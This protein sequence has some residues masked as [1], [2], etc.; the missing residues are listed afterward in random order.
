[1]ILHFAIALSLFAASRTAKRS[2]D[3]CSP[4]CVTPAQALCTMP[5]SLPGD[6]PH[7]SGGVTIKAGLGADPEHDP[8]ELDPGDEELAASCTPTI[9]RIDYD[10]PR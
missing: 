4:N 5:Y 7:F 1:M 8:F 6:C 2:A 10:R 9:C 3:F